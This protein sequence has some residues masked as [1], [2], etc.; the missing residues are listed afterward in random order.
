MGGPG[1]EGRPWFGGPGA[2]RR[3]PAWPAVRGRSSRP[4]MGR[5]RG[6]RAARSRRPGGGPGPRP[7]A[8]GGRP[9]RGCRGA[10]STGTPAPGW[11]RRRRRRRGPR[12][13]TVPQ[14]P[15]RPRGPRCPML[16]P[17]PPPGRDGRP[18]P[19]DCGSRGPPARRRCG[20][21]R[22]GI[23]GRHGVTVRCATVSGNAPRGPSTRGRSP[24]G[25][26]SGGPSSGDGAPEVGVGPHPEPWPEDPRLDPGLLAGGDR[27]N[28]ADRFRY[29]RVEAIVE[30]LDRT[31]FPFHV[32]IENFA[33]RPQHRHGGAQRERLRRRGGPRRGPASVEPA[34]R[35]GHRPLPARRTT[36]RTWTPWPGG[37]R[38]R[39]WSWWASTTSRGPPPS[40]AL[41]C[42]RDCV[43]LFGQEG[44]GLSPAAHAGLRP[45]ALHHHV[46]LHPLRQR[47][48]GLRHR[49][50][51][52]AQP[53]CS[54][55]KPTS[56]P[57]ASSRLCPSGS[58][59]MPQ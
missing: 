52:L 36:T 38:G 55:V 9:A 19:R 34:G 22:G 14:P 50:V 47:R 11:R 54:T 27:R 17:R 51:G 33:P 1:C 8:G 42:R 53:A 49:H 30:D 7:R 40:R 4:G 13:S 44:P 25:P 28:V 32:A 48:G 5:H 12:G 29:W 45:G 56:W 3:G 31:R 26:A 57:C 43:L 20:R 10:G 58:A 39:A 46:R 6:G 35:H 37:P 24:G 15:G 21:A 23:V 16:R 2:H 41:R 59:M 18:G